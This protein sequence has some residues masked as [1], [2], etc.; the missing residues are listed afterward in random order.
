MNETTQVRDVE[1]DRLQDIGDAL[2][3][4]IGDVRA[5]DPIRWSD[6]TGAWVVTGYQQ[7]LDAFSGQLPLSTARFQKMAVAPIPEEERADRIPY[8]MRTLPEWVVNVDA[9]VHTRLRKLMVKA[10]SR[11]IAEANRPFIRQA[12]AE[13]FDGIAGRDVEMVEQV[14]RHIPG[15]VILRLMGLPDS[16]LPRLRAWSLTLNSSLSGQRVLPEALERTEAALL[17]MR[18]LFLAEI[19][20]RRAVPGDDFLS[21]LVTARDG[22]DQLSE[23]ELLGICYITLIAGHDTTM[24]TMAL[25]TAALAHHPE[26]RDYIRAHPDRMPEIIAEIMRYVAM[27]FL[28]VRS[29]TEDFDWEGHPIK[30]GQFV[31]VVI[32]GGNRDPSVFPDPDRL[33]FTRPPDLSLTFAPGMHHC[34]GHLLAKVQLDEYFAELVQR[35]DPEMLD[36]RLHFGLSI[37]FRGLESLNMRFH[38]R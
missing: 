29:V 22:D 35:F 20:Q 3:E 24:N 14:L 6:R 27:S 26:A 16:L 34:I 11:K 13:A 5:A 9:P 10:F 37:G 32:A 28:K 12:I 4:Q 7:C 8:M 38:P 1:F 33:D 19:E 31:Y 15:R 2:F 21:M 36:D 17:E 25:G 18:A 23:E 30:A